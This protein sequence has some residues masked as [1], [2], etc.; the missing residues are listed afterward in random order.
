MTILFLCV[1]FS[2]FLYLNAPESY[3][4]IFSIVCL[5]NFLLSS[6]VMLK[7][8][9]SKTLVK[10]E[11][12]F[13]V[14]FFFTNIIY[15]VVYYPVNPYFFLFNLEFNE[16][17]INKGLALSVLAINVFNIGVFDK[18]GTIVNKLKFSR[19]NYHEPRFFVYLLMCM[20]LP[21]LIVAALT[22]E[23][24]VDFTRSN[25]NAI[26]VFVFYYILYAVFANN[27]NTFSTK[28]FL[29]SK[30]TSDQNKTIFL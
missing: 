4:Y 16:D 30:H 11:F 10:F 17:Y 18:G 13:I 3:S 19:T 5:V 24:V 2:L 8:N 20:Y 15:A 12:F 26:L 21:I 29:Y 1:I 7:N 14:A 22:N 6:F 28:S 27:S 9:C 25:I 23:Y